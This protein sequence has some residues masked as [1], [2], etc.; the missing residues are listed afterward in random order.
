MK[1]AIAKKWIAA[2]E[3]GEFKQAKNKLEDKSGACCCL[4]VLCNLALVEGVC[5]YENR[6]V[7]KYFDDNT[8]VL[9][10]SVL[11]WSGMKSVNG[12]IKSI[13]TDLATLNDDGKTFKEIAQLIKKHQKEL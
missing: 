6:C 13:G 4:G 7:Y 2:L 9:P 8:I 10:E 5:D 12:K 1:K 11:S 3:S